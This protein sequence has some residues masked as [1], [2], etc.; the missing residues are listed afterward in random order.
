MVETTTWRL[1]RRKSRPYLRHNFLRPSLLHFSL[2]AVIEI[3]LSLRLSISATHL[4][5]FVFNSGTLGKTRLQWSFQFIQDLVHD[6][7]TLQPLP[8]QP[9]NELNIWYFNDLN[10]HFLIALSVIPF[11]QVA[12][13]FIWQI[14][15][16]FNRPLHFVASPTPFICTSSSSLLSS[17][18]S[19]FCLFTSPFFLILPT[20]II[21]LIIIVIFYNSV[22]RWS[23][24]L[25]SAN[26]RNT[27]SRSVQPETEV[28]NPRLIIS[29]SESVFWA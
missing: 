7:I 16:R 6:N 23:V 14:Q 29:H 4:S 18:W 28:K 19:N 11:G 27:S 9:P 25:L 20:S 8:D 13:G 10:Q 26:N 21:R 1:I 17:I 12:R 5:G 24:P 2:N 3:L 15:I 22:P